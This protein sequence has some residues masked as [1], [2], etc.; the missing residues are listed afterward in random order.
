[1]KQVLAR[2]LAK[3][4]TSGA[5]LGIG[6]GSTTELILHAIGERI[7]NEALEVSGIVTSLRSATVA[8]Q[9]GIRVL[10]SR[11][12]ITPDW[13]FDGADEVDPELQ[14]IKGRGAAMFA[15]KVIALRSRGKLVIAVT[16][17][18]LVAALGQKCALPV[19][20]LPQAAPYVERELVQLGAT[21]V[22]LRSAA[23]K[24]GEVVTE[25]GN[26]V[27]DVRFPRIDEQLG[28]RVKALCG[29]IETGLFWNFNPEVIVIAESGA[30]S[31]SKTDDGSIVRAVIS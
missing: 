31:L 13:A 25:F 29:V 8:Q 24:Y 15:E 17:D 18:K 27:Y 9:A 22:T 23:G 1:M 20:V 6:S 4:V 19:E 26:V 2:I 16:E 21:E 7:R 3:R 11:T 12:A 10:D 5:V 14:L 28:A 30:Y